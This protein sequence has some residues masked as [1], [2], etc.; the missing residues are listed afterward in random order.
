MTKGELTQ[1]QTEEVQGGVTVANDDVRASV[2]YKA[3][4]CASGA[5]PVILGAPAATAEG[6]YAE[7]LKESYKAADC[8]K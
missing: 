7:I 5:A 1:K 8:S 4:P 2:H 3:A 6:A